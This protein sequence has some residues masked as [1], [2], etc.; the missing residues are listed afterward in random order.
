MDKDLC[1]PAQLLTNRYVILSIGLFEGTLL[2]P[3]LKKRT[4][5]ARPES[6]NVTEISMSLERRISRDTLMSRVLI[7]SARILSTPGSLPLW[8]PL[9]WPLRWAKTLLPTL[10]RGRHCRALDP[11]KVLLPLS[12]FQLVVSRLPS[13]FWELLLSRKRWLKED[14]W[15]VQR[16]ELELL[17]LF[18]SLNCS[19]NY[20][21]HSGGTYGCITV[22]V[23]ASRGR[24]LSN[25]RLSETFHR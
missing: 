2:D 17:S 10:R 14:L 16:S 23:E 8:G 24:V 7:T 15:H 25:M 12:V 20:Y 13:R 5:P 1:P 19:H 22:G 4:R 21:H 6:H 18:S 3:S 11:L 9:Q